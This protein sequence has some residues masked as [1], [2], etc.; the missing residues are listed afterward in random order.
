M[1]G[2][3]ASAGLG[4]QAEPRGKAPLGSA[5]ANC[6]RATDIGREGG[7]WDIEMATLL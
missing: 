3:S 7:V 1:M 4:H 5:A 2:A 6:S